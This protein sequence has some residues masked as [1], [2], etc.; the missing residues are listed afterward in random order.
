MSAITDKSYTHTFGS[1]GFFWYG[2]ANRSVPAYG[3]K[4][5]YQRDKLPF[6]DNA[7][8]QQAGADNKPLTRQAIIKTADLNA[9]RAAVN[10]N[11]AL[12][13][14][15]ESSRTAYL[16]DFDQGEVMPDN[17]GAMT[18]TLTFEF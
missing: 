2:N 4:A 15:Y 14:Q 3:R 12:A 17:A 13:I 11:A 8:L 16:A 10:S 6:G 1:L 7:V 9:W 18:V 5:I